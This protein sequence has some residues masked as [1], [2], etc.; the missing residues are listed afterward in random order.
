MASGVPI[1]DLALF[2]LQRRGVEMD[3]GHA[4]GRHIDDRNTPCPIHRDDLAGRMFG[5]DVVQQH[6]LKDLGDRVAAGGSRLNLGAQ[7]RA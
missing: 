4:A 1:H 7:L 6:H 5:F 2:N 3:D